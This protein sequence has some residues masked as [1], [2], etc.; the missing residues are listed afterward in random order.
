MPLS[1]LPLSRALAIACA[2]VLTLS[3]PAAAQQPSITGTFAIDHDVVWTGDQV[4]LTMT[5][6]L[7]NQGDRPAHSVLV[8]VA[9]PGAPEEQVEIAPEWVIGVF[10]LAEIGP[11]ASARVKARMAIPGEEWMRWQSGEAP[12]FWLSSHDDT[13]PTGGPVTL[14]RTGN[15]ST[16]R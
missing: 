1:L 15:I 2:L 8:S 11:G 4:V 3:L 14:T 10:P 5:L 6:E 12:A 13:W 7:S 9:K 16:E